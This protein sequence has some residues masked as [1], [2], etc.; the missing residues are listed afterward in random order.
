[1]CEAGAYTPNAGATACLSCGAGEYLPAPTSVACLDCVVGMHS[2][3]GGT[4]SL[5]EQ[6]MY[7][8]QPGAVECL[9]CNL[10]DYLPSPTS[11]ACA[12][13]P[14]GRARGR[15]QTE[16]SACDGAGLYTPASGASSCSTCAMN[17]YA[18]NA[19]GVRSCEICPQSRLLTCE[20]GVVALEQ[21]AWYGAGSWRKETNGLVGFMQ[22]GRMVW[23]ERAIPLNMHTKMHECFNDDSCILHGDDQG[24]H[25]RMKCNTEGGYYGPLCGGCDME[26]DYL[27]NGYKC[28]K[29]RSAGENVIVVLIIVGIILVLIVYTAAWRSTRQRQGEYGGIYRRIAFSYVQMVGVL[30]LFKARG[31]KVFNEAVGESSQILGG[32]LTSM[33]PIKC[34]LRTQV[35]GPYIIN[36]IAP[37]VIAAVV[38]LVLIP[39][40]LVRRKQESFQ[41]RK[42]HKLMLLKQARA[43]TDEEFTDFEAPRYEPVFDLGKRYCMVSRRMTAI[44]CC[45]RPAGNEYINN[46]RRQAMGEPN[47]APRFRAKISFDADTCGGIPYACILSMKCCRVKT[48]TTE[49]HAWRAKEAV[50]LQRDNFKPDRRFVSVMVLLMYAIYPTLVRSTA[51]IFNCTNVIDGLRYLTADLTV[52]CYEGWHNLCVTALRAADCLIRLCAAARAPPPLTATAPSH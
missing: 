49:R 35:Y 42:E 26:K 43:L 17:S 34:L 40:V 44:P 48:S 1:M 29:C 2:T 47:Y 20:N 28:D 33:L 45:R 30:G 5:C 41:R 22:S 19:S 10:G 16:C 37:P 6:G 31:T 15:N 3:L 21:T 27:R 9:A 38:V 50:R 14:I 11:V 4:C 8:P 13:C 12:K 36:M 32:G 39:T 18:T 52:T 23:V 7:T 46:T 25:A 51:T 24:K